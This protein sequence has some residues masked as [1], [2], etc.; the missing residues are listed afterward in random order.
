[1]KIID[2]Q[3]EVGRFANGCKNDEFIIDHQ[4][5][6]ASFANVDESSDTW[7]A[8]GL[9]LSLLDLLNITWFQVHE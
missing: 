3:K 1:M 8:C 6:K 4:I 7:M 2:V 5:Q 9:A